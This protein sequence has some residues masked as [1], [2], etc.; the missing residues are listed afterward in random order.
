MPFSRKIFTRQNRPVVF[1][2]TVDCFLVQFA[3]YPVT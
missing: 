1:L 3:F 2:V